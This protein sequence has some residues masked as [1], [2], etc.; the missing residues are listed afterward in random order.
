MKV[1]AGL[2]WGRFRSSNDDQLLPIRQ[3]ELFKTRSQLLTD[4]TLSDAER[5]DRISK[6]DAD[7]EK[8]SERMAALE[9]N[10]SKV[11]QAS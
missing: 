11:A 8:L 1:L 2:Q 10:G 3:L 7:L 9:K 6:I 4:K 5:N